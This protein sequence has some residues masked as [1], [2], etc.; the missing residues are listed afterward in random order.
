MGRISM[1][2]KDNIASI[3]INNTFNKPSYTTIW[4]KEYNSNVSIDNMVR[5]INNV[6]KNDIIPMCDSMIEDMKKCIL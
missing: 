3:N 6:L 2:I 1:Y 5:D 4:K